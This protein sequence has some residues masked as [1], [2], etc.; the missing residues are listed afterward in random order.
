MNPPKNTKQVRVFLRLV[1]YY[2][3][4]IKNFVHIAKPLTALT[5]HDAMFA[6]TSHHLTAFNTL[7][8]ALLEAPILHNPD[9]SKHYIVYMDVSHD[10]CGAQLSQ[11]HDGQKLP[12]AFLSHIFTDTQWK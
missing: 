12:V 4:F 5:H 9:P 8:S 2:H 7:K 11:K 1:G 6:W 10:V 3:K